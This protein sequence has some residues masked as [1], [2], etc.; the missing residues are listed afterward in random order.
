MWKVKILVM[1]EIVWRP[2]EATMA[3]HSIFGTCFMTTWPRI[4]FIFIFYKKGFFGKSLR[5][6]GTVLKMRTYLKWVEMFPP[7]ISVLLSAACIESV[8]SY[9]TSPV[10]VSPT[11]LWAATQNFTSTQRHYIAGS[12]GTAAEWG[13]GRQGGKEMW[14]GGPR[15]K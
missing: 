2:W 1:Q 11:L 14:S 10:D 4:F 5:T 13:E 12:S 15:G 9:H 6:W 3:L 7:D 8:W